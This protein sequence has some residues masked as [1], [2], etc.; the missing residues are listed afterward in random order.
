M[1]LTS[2]QM[3]IVGPE[4]RVRYT[5]EVVRPSGD[6]GVSSCGIRCYGQACRHDYLEFRGV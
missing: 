5:V 4:L 1:T 6:P 3:T 2:G